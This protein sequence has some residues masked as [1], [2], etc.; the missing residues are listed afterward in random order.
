MTGV[1]EQT[2]G[3]GEQMTKVAS[4]KLDKTGF[5]RSLAV[6]S[7]GTYKVAADLMNQW[8]LDIVGKAFDL[9]PPSSETTSYDAA[10]KRVREYWSMQL[11]QRI[12]FVKA[13]ATGRT[14]SRKRGRR[15]KQLRLRHL[16]AQ[17]VY[18]KRGLKGLYGKRMAKVAAA[19][20]RGAAVS[21]AFMKARLIPII[22]RLQ[23]TAKYK[24]PAWRY[25]Q[26]AVWDRSAGAYFKPNNAGAVQTV[27]TAL[28]SPNTEAGF[29]LRYP[30]KADEQSFVAMTTDSAMQRAIAWKRAK[31][32]READRVL[33]RLFDKASK[34]TARTNARNRAV[35]VDALADAAQDAIKDAF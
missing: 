22:R 3:V 16:I 31:V 5:S 23:P 34:E 18:R 29:V 12:K 7:N 28:P 27:R 9:I 20:S 21:V 17:A 10:R 14:V 33:K 15:N 32:E 2:T 19:M 30:V 24:F 35:Q 13:K 26:I 6:I 11:S 1:G 8:T 4:I 25:S